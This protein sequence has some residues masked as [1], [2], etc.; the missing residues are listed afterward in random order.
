MD[1]K[2]EQ[3][4]ETNTSFWG[5]DNIFREIFIN[6]PSLLISLTYI[7]ISCVGYFYSFWLL[8][9]FGI[10]Y[11][12][13]AEIPDFFL[14]AFGIPIDFTWVVLTLSFL[15]FFSGFIIFF[16]EITSVFLKVSSDDRNERRQFIKKWLNVPL[17]FFI[18]FITLAIRSL[19]AG[20]SYSFHDA[21]NTAEQIKNGDYTKVHVYM[22]T[23]EISVPRYMERRNEFEIISSTFKYIFLFDLDSKQAIVI[24]KDAI[25]MVTFGQEDI[26][27]K[28]MGINNHSFPGSQRRKS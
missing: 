13:Y 16:F 21:M 23:K 26:V 28:K 10:N 7:L 5:N 9:C 25:S 22:K 8:R 18:L 2:S 12:Q 19:G 24:P 6:Q 27:V 11:F 15:P 20:L 4:N 17:V 1:S 3:L 14:A